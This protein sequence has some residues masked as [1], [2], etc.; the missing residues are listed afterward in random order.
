MNNKVQSV[1]ALD[2]LVFDEIEFKRLD[3]K[4]DNELQ[5]SFG[6]KISENK[7]DKNKY[8]TT[9]EI[10]G[11]KEKEYTF[12]V[13]LS[14][15][16]SVNGDNIDNDKKRHLLESNSIAILM[17]YLRSQ[18]STLTA[19][20]NMDCVV[21]PVFNVSELLKQSGIGNEDE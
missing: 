16:F 4:N 14:G 3:F 11:K 13:R 19:Q 10:K 6:A 20:P 8:V 12:A 18:I 1:L 7:E 21:L 15:Y 2:E 9:V 17:P 5:L